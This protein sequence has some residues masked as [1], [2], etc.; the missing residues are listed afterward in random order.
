MEKEKDI[1]WR[2]SS[3]EDLRPEAMEGLWL[4]Q[5]I[6]GHGRRFLRLCGRHRPS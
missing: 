5:S 2:G 3:Y 4:E 1:D 6:T